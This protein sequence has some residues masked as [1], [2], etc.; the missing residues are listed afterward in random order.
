MFLLNPICISTHKALD[1]YDS[2]MILAIAGLSQKYKTYWQSR[3]A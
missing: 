3:I 1:L 2:T